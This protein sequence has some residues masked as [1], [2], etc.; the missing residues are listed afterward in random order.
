M[1]FL[2]LERVPDS[3]ART[4]TKGGPHLQSSLA[5]SSDILVRLMSRVVTEWP[6]AAR[7]LAA[8]SSCKTDECTIMPC[9]NGPFYH[10]MDVPT[11]GGCGADRCLLVTFRVPAAGLPATARSR[12]TK[13]MGLHHHEV[14]EAVLVDATGD[15]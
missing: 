1:A 8:A 5:T 9:A 6:P 4:L 13:S 2:T 12:Q 14:I 15:V 10:R 3:S 7:Q 11:S